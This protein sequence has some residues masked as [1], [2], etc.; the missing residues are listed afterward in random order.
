M[1]FPMP[2]T[3]KKA[4]VNPLLK[5]P[6]LHKE[7]LKN[8]RPVS[9]LPFLGKLIEHVVIEQVDE[10]LSKNNLN[11]PLRSAYTPNNSTETAI[12]KVTKDRL[13]ALDKRQCVVFPGLSCSFWIRVLLSTP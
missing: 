11:E 12:V 9:N 7:D 1:E 8:Y 4:I 2:Q 3:L 5:K 10:H 13:R 6:T